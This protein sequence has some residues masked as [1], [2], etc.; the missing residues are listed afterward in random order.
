MKK[1]LSVSLGALLVVGAANAETMSTGIASVSYV[2]GVAAS[3][4]DASTIGTVT[5]ANM[6]TTAATVVG[7]IREVA[8]EAAAAQTTANAAQTAANAAQTTANTASTNAA[9][10]NNKITAMDLATVGGTG[11]VVRS[12]TQADGKVTATAEAVDDRPTADST[13]LVTSDG[14]YKALDKKLNVKQG[15]NNAGK[16][17]IVE[18]TSGELVLADIATQDEL[19][20][21]ASTAASGQTASQVNTAITNAIN[22]LDVASVGGEGQF[23]ITI[24]QEN[25]KIEAGVKSFVPTLADGVLDAPTTNAVYDA[26]A[27]KQNALGYTAEN[28]SNKVTSVTAASTDA[29]Y[30][31]AKAMYTALSGKLS[32]TGTAAKATADASGNVI[33][34]TYATKSELTTGLNGKLGTSLGSNA[35]SKAVIT[36]ASGNI[37]SGTIT[38]GMITDATIATADIANSAVTSAKIAD[39]TIAAGDI[40]TGA[41]TTAKILDG[42]IL[43][44]DISGNAA[45][46]QSK[47]SGLTTALAGKQNVVVDGEDGKFYVADYGSGWKDMFEA[48]PK[49][50]R[51]EQ[52]DVKCALTH[53]AGKYAWEVVRE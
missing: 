8:G 49:D 13:K 34:T 43:N 41:V 19:N 18:G 25:G 42:T 36:D 26:L 5:A 17:L 44:A 21:V 31:S 29:Q 48:M 15:T 50:D 24:E 9:T 22:T 53:K 4:Q 11:Q 52:A 30:P 46:A 40:A 7:A 14:V 51:C 27:L 35:A 37:T 32:T 33:T 28:T 2:D 38:S 6:G 3:K 16:G 39:G 45:I 20:A 23:V 12:V 10:A 47:I 1:I